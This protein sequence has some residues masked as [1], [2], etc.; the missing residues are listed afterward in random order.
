LDG[1]AHGTYTLES[2]LP[3]FSDPVPS[4]FN[5]GIVYVGQEIQADVSAPASVVTLPDGSFVFMVLD[6]QRH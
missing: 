6:F 5:G 2:N 1:S 3:I 4:A